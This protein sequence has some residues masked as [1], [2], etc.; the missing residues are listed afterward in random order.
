MAVRF[1]DRVPTERIQ[2]EARQVDLPRLLL[3]LLLGVFWLLGWLVGMVSVGIGFAYAAAKTGY[4]D[5]R[6]QAGRPPRA[7]SA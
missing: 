4:Q 5:A 2:A 6:S 7:R 1:L 3:N